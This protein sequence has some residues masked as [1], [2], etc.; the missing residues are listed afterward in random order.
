MP[1]RFRGGDT[2][3]LHSRSEVQGL[4]LN[5]CHIRPNASVGTLRAPRPFPGKRSS[6][7]Q[8]RRRPSEADTASENNISGDPG[9][10]GLLSDPLKPA[11]PH[12]MPDP[13]AGPPSPDPAPPRHHGN[14]MPPRPGMSRPRPGPRLAAIMRRRSRGGMPRALFRED[15][16]T[17][18]DDLKALALAYSHHYALRPPLAGKATIRR[19]AI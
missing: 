8:K 3:P 4:S 9:V 16:D 1:V 6:A 11:K 5:H 18:L 12:Q 17:S 2:R 7:M 19:T 15:D 14:W 10:G 13:S